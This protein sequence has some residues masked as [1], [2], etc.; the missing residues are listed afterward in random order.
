MSDRYWWLFGIN[1][2]VALSIAVL[3]D[4]LGWLKARVFRRSGARVMKNESVVVDRRDL[5]EAVSASVSTYLTWAT[6]IPTDVN[7]LRRASLFWFRML[8]GDRICP[9]DTDLMELIAEHVGLDADGRLYFRCRDVSV[10]TGECA[11]GGRCRMIATGKLADELTC[12]WRPA[13]LG[14]A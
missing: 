2:F 8:N 7:E 1:L 5:V 12:P 3:G 13:L 10:A 11:N 14:I 4:T 6:V 9:D